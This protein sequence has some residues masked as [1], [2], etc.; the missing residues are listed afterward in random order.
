MERIRRTIL[1]CH[2]TLPLLIFLTGFGLYGQK[3]RHT[4]YKYYKNYT[5]IDY[6]HHPQNWCIAQD[7][8]GIIY[9]GNR[10]GLL[11]FDGVKWEVKNVPNRIVRSMVFASDGRLY[12][13]GKDEIGYF[14]PGSRGVLSYVSLTHLLDDKYKKFGTV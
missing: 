9:V 11:I 5:Y 7:K 4:G 10:L 12:I 13:G 6:D 3:S 14:T 2:I 8:Q 1:T